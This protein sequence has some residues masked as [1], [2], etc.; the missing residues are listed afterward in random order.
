MAQAA[1][2]YRAVFSPE[3]MHQAVTGLIAAGYY[4]ANQGPAEV[5]MVKRKQFSTLWLIVGL[6][7]CIVP[8]L[9]YLIVYANEQDSIIILRL[10]DRPALAAPSP[11]PRPEHLTWTDDRAMW[12]DGERWHDPAISYPAS[13]PLSEDGLQWWDG[14]AW[15]PKLPAAQAWQGGWDPPIG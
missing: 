11:M 12:W 9:V 13:A 4:V 6:A 1:V 10:Q 7:L 2:E 8:L 3:M 15:R 5:T 14:A